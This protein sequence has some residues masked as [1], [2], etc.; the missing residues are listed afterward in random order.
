MSLSLSEGLANFYDQ[1]TQAG[2]ELIVEGNRPWSRAIKSDAMSVHPSQVKEAMEHCR[3]MGVPTD[4]T[5][6][7]RPILRDRNHR[8]RFMRAN[9][10]FDKDG[11]Y[12]DVAPL[13]F[14][15]KPTPSR[16]REIA[17]RLAD[18]IRVRRESS[19]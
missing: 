2:Q 15:G 16:L 1:Q 6:D 12:G 5:E 7:G 14:T 10:F 11:G 17:R 3:K 18:R 13:H 4:Y 8:A 9:Q 19:R